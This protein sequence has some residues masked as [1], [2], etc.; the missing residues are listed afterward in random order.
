MPGVTQ[1]KCDI[2]WKLRFDELVPYKR[3][4]GDCNVPY[5]H[6]YYPKLGTWVG[7]QRRGQLLGKLNAKRVEQLTLIGFQW[8]RQVAWEDR[9]DELKEYKH[10]HGHCNVPYR[11]QQ[12]PNPKLSVWVRLQRTNRKRG[13][14]NAERVELLDFIGFRWAR[15]P[16]TVIQRTDEESSLAAADQDN[17]DSYFEQLKTFRGEHGHCNVPADEGSCS[18]LHSWVA[19]QR[20]ERRTW[21][22]SLERETKLRQLGFVF[23]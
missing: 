7:T 4:F 18:E 22:L 15:G 8:T 12:N 9:Y 17:W 14:L 11:P 3:S 23:N 21:L 1:N 10:E 6:Q 16:R 13:R 19:E 20:Q 5:G 2:K